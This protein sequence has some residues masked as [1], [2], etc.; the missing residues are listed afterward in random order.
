MMA[1][2][3]ATISQ[4]KCSLRSLLSGIA[5]VAVF[6]VWLCW[7]DSFIPLV[8]PLAGVVAALGATAALRGPAPRSGL[9]AL[10]L[11]ARSASR[12]VFGF[13]LCVTALI[14]IASA[15]GCAAGLLGLHGVSYAVYASQW[16]TTD[17]DPRG[18]SKIYCDEECSRDSRIN[19][20]RCRI[21]PE[22]YRASRDQR[23]RALKSSGG[24]FSAMNAVSRR[25]I[26]MSA[27]SWWNP[28]SGCSEDVEC[29]RHVC[30]ALPDSCKQPFLETGEI[31]LYDSAAQTLWVVSWALPFLP[32]TNISP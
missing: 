10:T 30:G 11:G 7:I 23:S 28:P 16:D 29:F 13:A 19:Y 2:S 6:S 24:G 1:E 20:Y 25:E 3:E 32:V 31:W 17:F 26:A 21:S 12:Y 18:A 27:P 8:W 5:V 15:I 14:C 4:Y 22:D 9:E